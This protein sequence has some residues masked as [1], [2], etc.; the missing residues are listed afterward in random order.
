MIYHTNELYLQVQRQSNYNYTNDNNNK[1]IM[2]IGNIHTQSE[3]RI[4]SNFNV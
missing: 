3:Y 4:T 1:R 2:N